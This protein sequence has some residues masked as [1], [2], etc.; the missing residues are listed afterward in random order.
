MLRL[1]CLQLYVNLRKVTCPGVLLSKKNEIYLSVCIM[2]QYR[3][4]PCLPPIFP[5]RFHH[6]MVFVKVKSASQR[7]GMTKL[8]F[9][10]W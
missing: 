10:L 9:Y 1:K 2:G 8:R 5:L 4:T 6:K 3:K 7:H